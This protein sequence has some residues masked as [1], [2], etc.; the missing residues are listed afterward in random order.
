M[1]NYCSYKFIFFLK[2][3]SATISIPFMTIFD[4]KQPQ[5][6]EQILST[7]D[8]D[9]INKHLTVF[10]INKFELGVENSTARQNVMLRQQGLKVDDID[11]PHARH[12]ISVCPIS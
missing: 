2:A 7:N 12:L 9:P 6:V 10:S 5:F 8:D 4:L 3:D 11:W 1:T